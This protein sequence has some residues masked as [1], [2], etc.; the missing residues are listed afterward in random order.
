MALA[1]ALMLLA[2]A[3]PAVQAGTPAANA[4]PQSSPAAALVA[5]D[6]TVF[7]NDQANR[8]IQATSTDPFQASR[9]L[10]LE[11]IAVL[12][13][14]RSIEGGPA[15]LVHLPGPPDTR[16]G[17]A[18]AAAAHAMLNHLFPTRR[19]ELDAA[20]ATALANEPT[21]PPRERAE[22]L[23]EAVADAV[24]AVREGD[25]WNAAGQVRIGTGP[26]EW[27]PTPPQF[28]PPLDPQWAT[29]A[30]FALARPD[31]FRPPMPPAAGSAALHDAAAYVAS[32]G[33][34]HSS[35]RT[36][37]QTE[38]AQY[39]S[40]AIGTYAPAGHWNAI[41]AR[42]VAPLRLGFDAEAELFAEL[43]VA[44]ADSAIA[45]ADAKYTYWFWRPITVIR[46]GAAGSPPIPDWSPLLET[47]NHPSYISGHSGFSGAAAVVLTARFGARPFS[48]ASDSV[49]GVTRSFASF[50]QAAE[51]AA[52][53]RVLGG[54]H[55]P[56]DNAAGLATG[57]AV[58]EWT[59]AVFH[60]IAQDRGP[61]VVLDRP[62]GAAGGWNPVPGGYALDNVAPVTAVTVRL[63][64]GAPFPV[65]VDRRGRFRIPRQGLGLTGRREM[66]VK[67]TSV[68]GRTATAT[69]EIGGSAAD[70]AVAAPLTVQ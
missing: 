42:L 20:F 10:A 33:A 16:P 8:A 56:F 32:I 17:I 24:F 4:P 22:A 31:Q 46:A 13:A 12:D 37:E 40:D 52:F 25:G 70:G 14:I 45:I 7:W 62:E 34:A 66:L 21:G 43:N 47:P 41:T 15:F 19:A 55:Y 50:Q 51:E 36:A 5:G 57:R 35:V 1:A 67:A 68:T 53:S 44:I 63:D 69:A 6:Q 18:V 9:D 59:M 26:G 2:A 49:P 38:I 60:R 39:W 54:I 29:V 3:V 28:L 65:T 27:R 48:F 23:G 64:G 58:G 11:S 30:P 61:F